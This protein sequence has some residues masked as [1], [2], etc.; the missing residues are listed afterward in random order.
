MKKYKYLI[1]AVAL[2][3]AAWGCKKTEIGFLSDKLL[4]RSNPLTAIKGRV[5]TSAPLEAD[6][7]TQPMSV[8]L[9]DVRDASG[10]TATSLL[11]EHEIAIYRAEVRATDTTL[12]KL[13]A[14]LGTGMY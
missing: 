11:T 5:T 12:V 8:K 7:S 14:K 3:L 6:G 4:Y 1:F 10:K 13:A 9:L 2:V